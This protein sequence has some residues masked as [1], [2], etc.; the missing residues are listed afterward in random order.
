DH[1]VKARFLVTAVGCLSTPLVSD[2]PGVGDFDGDVYYTA[3]WPREGVDFT[4]KR[5]ALVGTGSSGIQAT[6]PIAAQ[7]EHL[8]VFQRTPNFS[9]PARHGV[10]LAEDQARIMS[11]YDEIFAATRASF[12]GFPF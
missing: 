3:T 11:N 1:T 9:L 4:G 8:T 12:A 7:A 10:F 6:P 5:V 2:I